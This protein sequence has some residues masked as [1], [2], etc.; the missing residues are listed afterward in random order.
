MRLA[1]E[2]AWATGKLVTELHWLYSMVASGQCDAGCSDD[3]QWM[4]RVTEHA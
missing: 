2:V 3:L 1:R 4:R